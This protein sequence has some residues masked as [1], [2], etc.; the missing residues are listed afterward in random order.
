[1]SR[2]I[3]DLPSTMN[4]IGRLGGYIFSY[5]VRKLEMRNQAEQIKLRKNN[6]F[7]S[8]TCYWIFK[9]T[10]YTRNSATKKKYLCDIHRQIPQWN[11][12]KSK[13]KSSHN[14]VICHVIS[15]VHRSRNLRIT[16]LVSNW[17]IIYTI[18][19]AH[20]MCNGRSRLC[21]RSPD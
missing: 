19:Q 12:F 15:W 16:E 14:S 3:E 6:S 18:R 13:P 21:A 4:W 20:L 11:F 1:M 10:I 8:F 9:I 5:R 17:V 2:N 7:S